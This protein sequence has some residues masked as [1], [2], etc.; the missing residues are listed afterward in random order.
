MRGSVAR[1]TNKIEVADDGG[2]QIV[3]VVRQSTCQLTDGFHLLRLHERGF[4]AFPLLHFVLQFEICGI[5]VRQTRSLTRCSSV[6]V[7]RTHA[8]FGL[9]DPQHSSHGG[10]KLQRFGRLNQIGIRT[11]IE[12]TGAMNEVVNVEDVIKTMTSGHFCL[13]K[14]QTS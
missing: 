14:A 13:M 8:V 6:C 9:P 10:S 1:K 5:R 11:G 4:G 3:E 12:A 7:Q 2:Q